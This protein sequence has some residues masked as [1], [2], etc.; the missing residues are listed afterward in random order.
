MPRRILFACAACETAL[1]WP[2]DA[3]PECTDDVRPVNDGSYAETLD[4]TGTPVVVIHPKSNWRLQVESCGTVMC[5]E[6]HVVGSSVQL[7]E[8]R[9]AFI[10]LTRA[11]IVQREMRG[12]V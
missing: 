7:G 9:P 11:Q 2:V 12:R 8:I 1:I 6:G 3:T 10:T 5:P 4:C